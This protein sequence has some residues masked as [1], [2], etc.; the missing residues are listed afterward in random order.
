MG[1]EPSGLWHTPMDRANS[2]E[3]TPF[4]QLA[5]SQIAGSHLSRPTGES[6]K[7]VPFFALYWYLQARHFHSR[8]VFR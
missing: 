1:H 7:I 8:R 2:C 4:L 3:D 6:S 5:M